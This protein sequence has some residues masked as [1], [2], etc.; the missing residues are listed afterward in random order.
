MFA[1]LYLGVGMET[2]NRAGGDRFLDRAMDGF[3]FSAQTLTPV[4]YGQ[5][6]P[7]GHLASAGVALE[8]MP[9]LLSFALATGLL[10]GRFSRPRAKIRVGRE[11]LAAPWRGGAGF[12]FRLANGPSSQCIELEASVVP[13]RLDPSGLAGLAPANGRAPY[14][15][16]G[17]GPHG[18][19]SLQ[20]I[21]TRAME[22]RAARPWAG[23]TGCSLKV[24]SFFRPAPRM[25]R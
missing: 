20:G 16:E 17:G 21:S 12:R 22:P 9:G 4:G 25:A 11:A 13:S 24:N 6:S 3:F 19:G 18:A 2:F 8:S 23:S 15:E 7:R 14:P 5:I 1:A 10:R